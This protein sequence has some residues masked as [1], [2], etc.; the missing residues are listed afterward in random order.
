MRWSSCSSNHPIESLPLLAQNKKKTP[1]L[2]N[3]ACVHSLDVVKHAS[4]MSGVQ[5]MSF[6]IEI[7]ECQCG[8]R[9]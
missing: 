6:K 1:D 5:L 8:C 9:L 2:K 4:R 7:L 3:G